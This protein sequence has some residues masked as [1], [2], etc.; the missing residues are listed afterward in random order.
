MVTDFKPLFKKKKVQIPFSFFSVWGYSTFTSRFKGKSTEGDCLEDKR[1]YSR[2]PSLDLDTQWLYF[3]CANLF[4]P[5]SITF[6]LAT[7]SIWLCTSKSAADSSSLTGRVGRHR[8]IPRHPCHHCKTRR[9]LGP[10][11]FS[12]FELFLV[13]GCLLF[14]V[15]LYLEQYSTITQKNAVSQVSRKQIEQEA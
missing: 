9:A 2:L 4:S 7:E 8:P 12:I 6:P 13:G 10:Q 1:L 3:M 14:W 15:A 5:P 11:P